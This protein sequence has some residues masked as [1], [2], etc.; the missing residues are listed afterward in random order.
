M[1]TLETVLC[2]TAALSPDSK[3]KKS[4]DQRTSKINL[5]LKNSL[6]TSN[7]ATKN[8]TSSEK[9]EQSVGLASISVEA[10]NQQLLKNGSLSAAR[11]SFV[12]GVKINGSF[13]LNGDN[14]KSTDKSK[15]SS[16]NGSV[17]FKPVQNNVTI[18]N[19]TIRLHSNGISTGANNYHNF[20]CF[21]EIKEGNSIPA[22]IASNDMMK[23][24]K[25]VKMSTVAKRVPLINTVGNH[26]KLIP[27]TM[28]SQVVTVSTGSSDSSVSTVSTKT[29]T[30]PMSILEARLT[31]ITNDVSSQ[32]SEK[33]A[34]KSIAEPSLSLPAFSS[35]KLCSA[36]EQIL[37]RTGISNDGLLECSELVPSKKM[38]TL[39]P[40]N[41]EKKSP[42]AVLGFERGVTRLVALE[43]RTVTMVDVGMQVFIPGEN[44]EEGKD[45]PPPAVSS[46]LSGKIDWKLSVMLSIFQDIFDGFSP[47]LISFKL[48]A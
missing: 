41:Q 46:V 42:K 4:M 23:N 20:K 26:S 34:S 14:T 10:V 16:S 27:L 39:R 5:R 35:Q 11:N 43:S 22:N 21:A 2:S 36:R 45:T 24:I 6:Y 15:H 3:T 12:Y 47:V 32:Q 33:I 30:K 19:G 40:G 18:S 13:N 7:Q 38:K 44:D 37:K 8:G 1:Q 48:P 9:C 29:V 31:N 17:E 28:P 25:K